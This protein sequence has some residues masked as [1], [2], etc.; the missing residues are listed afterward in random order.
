MLKNI[1]DEFAAY[2][3]NRNSYSKEERK[4][5]RAGLRAAL[6]ELK[7]DEFKKHFMI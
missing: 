7:T 5:I 3:E 4:Q 1:Q 6:F 2:R